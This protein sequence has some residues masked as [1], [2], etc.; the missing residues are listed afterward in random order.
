[1][2]GYIEM[3]KSGG[4]QSAKPGDCPNQA[5]IRTLR[6]SEFESGPNS[7]AVRFNSYSKHSTILG[8]AVD[9]ES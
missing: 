3:A 1:M 7:Q 8:A 2:R 5:T 6:L 9:N 4:Q